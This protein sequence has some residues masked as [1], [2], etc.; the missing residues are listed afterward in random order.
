[1]L[2]ID[3]LGVIAYNSVDMT[4]LFTFASRIVEMSRSN[5]LVKGSP[6]LNSAVSQLKLLSML[7]WL[8]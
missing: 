8:Y 3:F 6:R 5:E 2:N 1:M 7:R 4:Y